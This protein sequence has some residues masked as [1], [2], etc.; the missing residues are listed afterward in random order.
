MMVNDPKAL[1]DLVRAR[2]K[3]QGLRQEEVALAAGT[4]RRFVSELENGK[5]TVRLEEVL[6]VLRALGLA[7]EVTM[8]QARSDNHGSA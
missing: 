1:G 3:A 6:K 5:P 2:R 8:R 4:G 7:I